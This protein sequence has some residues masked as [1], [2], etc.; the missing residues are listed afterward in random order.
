MSDIY[1]EKICPHNIYNILFCTSERVERNIK[2]TPEDEIYGVTICSTARFDT[3][4]MAG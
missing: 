2:T 1:K 4:L 3:F